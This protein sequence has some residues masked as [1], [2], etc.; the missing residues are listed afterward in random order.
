MSRNTDIIRY[1]FRGSQAPP[2]V[3]ARMGDFCSLLVAA[4]GAPTVAAVAGGPM[5]LALAAN[6]EVESACLY[7]GNILPFPITDLIRVEFL[8]RVSSGAVAANN[9]VVLGVGTAQ[10]ADPT[11]VAQAAMFRLTGSS[12]VLIDTR[13][14]TNTVAGAATGDTLVATYKRLMIDF[15]SG[16]LTQSP[17]AQSLGG[18]ADVKFFMSNVNGSLRQVAR[19]Q[20]FRM[21]AFAGNL[22]IIAQ[23]Q[24]TGGVAQTTVQILGI[25]VDVKLPR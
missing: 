16:S 13:D 4:A 11:L 3:A 6:D 10:N 2:L 14:G 25:D 1:R 22:Q 7:Q 5:Q 8:A 24:K 12:A 15:A 18:L 23:V 17:P 19:N 9:Q 20:A 21:D